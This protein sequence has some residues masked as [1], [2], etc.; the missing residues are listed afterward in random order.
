[1]TVRCECGD[2]FP[3]H[4]ALEIKCPTCQARPGKPCVRPSEHTVFRGS[5]GLSLHRARRKAAFAAK[6]CSCLRLW[7]ERQRTKQ[8]QHDL[9]VTEAIA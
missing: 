9:F 4:P 2:E 3:R 5:D 8:V 6:P 1:M 7:E